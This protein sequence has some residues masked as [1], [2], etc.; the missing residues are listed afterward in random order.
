MPAAGNG[1][2]VMTPYRI[3]T[4]GL[5]ALT[6]CLAVAVA[7]PRSATADD[8]PHSTPLADTHGPAGVMF[9]H[10]HKAGE[11]MLG[12]RYAGTYAGG[13]ILHNKNSVNDHE[14]AD[15]GCTPH[16]CSRKP[17]DMTAGHH[18]CTHKLDDPYGH[19]HV[20]EPR[21]DHVTVGRAGA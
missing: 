16:A 14:I 19:A 12:Y 21:H 8:T 6:L 3:S 7:S 15:N 2:G 20:D 10:M 13:D 17:T 18:V 11:F 4:L 5:P 1:S 9:D